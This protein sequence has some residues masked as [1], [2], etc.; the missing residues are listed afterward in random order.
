MKLSPSLKTL[1]IATFTGLASCA[2]TCQPPVS[3]ATPESVPFQQVTLQD[4]FW[5]PRLLAQ[6][7]TLVP[8]SLEKNVRDNS[9]M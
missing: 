5:R 4:D 9:G 3:T 7:H 1:V 6:K 8:F 2:D